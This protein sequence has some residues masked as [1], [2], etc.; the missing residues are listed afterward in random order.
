MRPQKVDHQH[1][2]EGLMSV[3][4]EKG[5]EGSSLMDLSAATGLKKASLYHRFPGGKKE[6]AEAVLNYVKAWNEVNILGV[7]A[8]KKLS[9]KK[10]LDMA[11]DNI[12]LLYDQGKSTCILR[13]M[14][15]EA[16]L[17]IFGNQ[18]E[19]SFQLWI[20]GFTIL[21]IDLGSSKKKGHQLAQ[22][23]IIRVQG[24]LILSK[25]MNDITPFRESMDYIKKMY[26]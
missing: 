12:N 17:P 2:M 24:A 1:L 13:A 26:Q 25:G 8:N 10:R 4:R 20:D 11:I 3:L 21:A 15:T 16:S 23:V 5:F 9:P 18:I 19:E 14:T 22:E 6:I 7:L